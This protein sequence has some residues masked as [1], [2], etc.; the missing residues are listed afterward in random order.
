MNARN[1]TPSNTITSC[2]ILN[3][4]HTNKL[5]S[6]VAIS[7]QASSHMSTNLLN[8]NRI[9][10]IRGYAIKKSALTAVQEERLKEELNV[11]PKLPE[12]FAKAVKPFPIYMESVTRYYVPRAWG[13][14]AY[15]PPEVNLLPEGLPLPATIKFKGTP[16]DYQAEIL[17]KFDAAGR[18]GLLCVPCGKGKTFMALAAAVRT[19]RRFMVVVDKE[20]FLNQWKGEMEAFV[21]GLRVGILQGK[22]AEI[23][24]DR[25]DC[26]ICMLQ[27]L[28]LHEYP[29]GY[30]NGYGLAIFDECHKLGAPHFCKALQKVQPRYLLGL[31]ATPV[32]DDGM[33]FVF[34]SFLGKPFHWDK[35]REPDPTVVVRGVHF[36]T[37]SAEY[38]EVPINWRGEP[39]LARLLS[40]VVE[41]EPRTRRILGILTEMCI[42]PKRKILVLSE[43]KI[44]LENLE[45]M[46]KALPAPPTVGYYVG[47]MKQEDLDATAADSQVVLATYAMANEGLNIKTLNAVILASPRKK[48][49]QSTGRILRMRPEERSIEPVI[50]DIIDPHET[51]KRQWRVRNSYYKKCGYNIQEEGRP[52]RTTVE[53]AANADGCMFVGLGLQEGEGDEVS[54]EEEEEEDD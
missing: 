51:Y 44:L 11:S 35:V 42:E 17:D 25:Y 23:D 53:I 29:E 9:L 5:K 15:G 54:E 13:L 10:S 14:T 48:V 39:I 8:Y 27:T 1:R 52:A 49:E 37:D 6:V 16:H 34:E 3:H 22:R 31:S 36:T 50:V 4:A 46:L 18:C 7:R 24:P 19:G 30:F 20:F 32:R 45:I 21:D 26:L 2:L 43:R 41:F 47:G 40:K 38:K 12:R 33:T 28:A